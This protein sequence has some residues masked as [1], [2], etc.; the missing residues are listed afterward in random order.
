MNEP[1]PGIYRHFKGGLYRVWGTAWRADETGVFVVYE[2]Q[3]GQMWV[4]L[5]CDF[6]RPVPDSDVPRFELLRKISMV[7]VPID[8]LVQRIHDI[9]PTSP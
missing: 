8:E 1:V 4:R 7:R 9:C 5:L 2:D 6:N 3:K